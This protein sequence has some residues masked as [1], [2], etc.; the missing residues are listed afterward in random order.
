M[1]GQFWLSTVLNTW[2]EEDNSQGPANG[3]DLPYLQDDLKVYCPHFKGKNSLETLWNISSDVNLNTMKENR[4][5]MTHL[6]ANRICI[7]VTKLTTAR[8]DLW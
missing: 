7:N 1:I 3:K 5:F 4:A 2:A 8:R 6:T